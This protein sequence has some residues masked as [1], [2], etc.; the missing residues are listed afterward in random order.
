MAAVPAR[1][2]AAPAVSVAPVSAPG[3][4]K[5]IAA[6]ALF[7]PWRGNGRGRRGR[8]SGRQD[9]DRPRV[10]HADTFA[11]QIF[12]IAQR[13]MN[14]PAF[15]ARHRIEVERHAGA[16]HFFGRRQRAHSQLLD[17]QSA[18]IVRIEGNQRMI[19]YRNP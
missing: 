8:H 14:H 11:A 19:F 1:A 9:Y 2:W 15:P 12:F 3:P 10:P 13:E 4:A 6:I 7:R 16:L 18:I 17:P 5:R